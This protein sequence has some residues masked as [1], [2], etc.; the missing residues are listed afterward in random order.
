[1]VQIG[2]WVTQYRKGFWLIVDIKPKYAD[3]DYFSSVA[4][5]QRKKGD[6]IGYWI[7]MKKGFT[8]QMKFRIDSDTADSLWCKPVSTDTLNS[9]H[10]YF[11]KNPKDYQKFIDTPFTDKPAISTTWLRLTEEQ[12]K[13]FQNIIEQ[14]PDLFTQDEAMQLFEKYDLKQCFSC[15]PSNYAFVCEHTLWELDKNFTPLF[16]NP[17]LTT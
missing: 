10:E 3:D 12:V 9:I 11:E 15:P 5:K 1:M 16:K 17:R 13:S 7:L 14:L 6:L 2:D 4:N 8:P